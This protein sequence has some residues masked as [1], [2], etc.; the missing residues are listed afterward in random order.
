M[1]LVR[2]TLNQVASEVLVPP[3]DLQPPTTTVFPSALAATRYTSPRAWVFR[4]HGIDLMIRSSSERHFI[5]G[6]T[7]T[8]SRG[9]EYFG[10][11]AAQA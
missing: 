5:M 11:A 4:V 3:A 7:M 8:G 1:D 9:L 6:I 2:V 10:P